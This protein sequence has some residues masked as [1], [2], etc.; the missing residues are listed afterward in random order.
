MNER[1]VFFGLLAGVFKRGG[2]NTRVDLSRALVHPA[3]KFHFING[4]FVNLDFEPLG[5]RV[6]DRRADAVQTARKLIVVVAELAA[7]VQ[8]RENDFHARNFRRRV[9]IGRYSPAVIFYG[10]ASVGI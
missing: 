4:I 2:G 10:N 3:C 6:R 5:Q 7:G 8:L 1:A 9:N